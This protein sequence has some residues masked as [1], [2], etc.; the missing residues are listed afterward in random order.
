MKRQF[1]P[2]KE[3]PLSPQEDYLKTSV[4]ADTLEKIIKRTPSNEVFTIGL[5]G[6]WGTGKSSII[7]TTKEKFDQSK[8]RFITYDAW[9]YCNDS[10][11]RMF[12]RKIRKDL[13]LEQTPEM[14]RF[15]Q[16]ETAETEPKTYIST[17][18]LLI[19]IGALLLLILLVVLIP[20]TIDWKIPV[21]SFLTLGDYL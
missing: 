14:E 16:S 15:Y 9:K 20:I 8:V 11:R 5:F 3:K 17:P 19:I 4:Y 6:N 12:L 13:K 21:Y 1:I 10:F 2:D 18:N 7:E